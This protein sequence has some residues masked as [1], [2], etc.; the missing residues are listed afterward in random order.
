MRWDRWAQI[1]RKI[2]CG[3][4]LLRTGT[5]GTVGS[6]DTMVLK[7]GGH[8]VWISESLGLVSVFP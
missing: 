3:W 1:A 6:L 5:K 8:H 7:W 4:E 2:S